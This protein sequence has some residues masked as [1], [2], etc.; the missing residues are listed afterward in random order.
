MPIKHSA[1]PIAAFLSAALSAAFAVGAAAA[2]A[3][4]APRQAN[5]A[6]KTADGG[7]ASFERFRNRVERIAAEHGAAQPTDEEMGLADRGS[8]EGNKDIKTGNGDK[9]EKADELLKAAKKVSPVERIVDMGI[10]KVRAVKG[11]DGTIMYIADMGR[12]A[13]TGSVY[14]LWQKKQLTTIE[15][16]SDAVSR[17]DLS[18]LNLK[19][20]TL[21]LARFGTG[22]EHVTIFVDPLCGW[23]HK[24]MNEV[25]ADA[26]L[27]DEYTF[28][29]LVIPALGGSSA[30]LAERLF[31]SESNA[32]KRF[33]VLRAGR[34]GI[35]RLPE[36]S[37]CAN[38]GYERT[39]MTATFLGVEAVP[40]VIAPD[41][42]FSRGK[43]ASLRGFL[44]GR[45]T[46]A[47]TTPDK[48][49]KH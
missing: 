18:G 40:F 21:N 11:R 19:L 38:E 43:P 25:V 34:E 13:F 24:L 46:D 33:D 27:R 39:Q 37:A 10:S 22:R 3:P 29:F 28:D 26:S 12:F 31:C 8:G 15:E 45:A 49:S 36:S 6:E 1:K 35:E 5:T 41:G 2:D 30:K 14:D 20:E 32:E 4:E 7:S 42:R 16:I 44:R 17:M 23:C 47:G 48:R 9:A